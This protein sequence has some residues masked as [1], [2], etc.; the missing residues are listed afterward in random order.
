MVM[1]V[2]FPTEAPIDLTAAKATV[3]QAF[4]AFSRN[5]TAWYSPC[6]DMW[7]PCGVQNVIMSQN[8]YDD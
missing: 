1:R 3:P 4:L 2:L 7:S 5:A 8:V 6:L